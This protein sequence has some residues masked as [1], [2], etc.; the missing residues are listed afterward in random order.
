MNLFLRTRNEIYGRRSIL[1]QFQLPWWAHLLIT[2]GVICAF[3]LHYGVYRTRD[4]QL[5][6]CN[7][8]MKQ[9]GLFVDYCDQPIVP[10]GSSLQASDNDPGIIARWL[11]IARELVYPSPETLRV[12]FFGETRLA[13][14]FAERSGR[15]GPGV[16]DD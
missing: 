4:L 10:Q 2:V 11:L 7:A 9:L 8:T 5:R 13:R 1:N 12:N 16:S 14:A 15:L 3:A 6:R